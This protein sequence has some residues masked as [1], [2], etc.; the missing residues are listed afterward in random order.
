LRYGDDKVFLATYDAALVAVDAVTGEQ[1]WRSQKADYREAVYTQCG[2]H[3]CQWRRGEWYQR[4]R[5]VHGGWLFYH[6]P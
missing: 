4:M 1:L 3:R 2:T 5:A 6:G